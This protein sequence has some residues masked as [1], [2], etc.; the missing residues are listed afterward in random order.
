M[1]LPQTD[2]PNPVPKTLGIVGCGVVGN[3]M[4]RAFMEWCSVKIYDTDLSRRTHTLDEVLGCEVIMVCLPT[5]Q[6]DNGSYQCDTRILNKFF[7]MVSGHPG[8]FALRSTVPIGYTAD[9]FAKHR[10]N[11]VHSPEFLTAR[12][13]VV[14]AQCPARNIIGYP[15]LAF[16]GKHLHTPEQ[17]EPHPLATLYQHRFKG[18]PLFIM[19]SSESEAVKLFQNSFFAVKVAFFNE[20]NELSNKKG[21]CWAKIQ[22]AM[23]ADG[24]IAHSHTQ[25]PGP[26]GKYG[27]GGACLPKDL[28]NLFGCQLTSGAAGKIT[29]AA[30]ERNYY[31]R[32][33]RD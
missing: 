15:Y 7:E 28:G 33:R 32:D 21:M 11:I 14:D 20:L 2:N 8:S 9:I 25:V 13:S 1:T 26:D 23:L 3:A 24:R 18:T 22:K 5:P 12:C 4:A 30:L 31:D 16:E 27:F 10:L 17:F 29:K 19:S 6:Y